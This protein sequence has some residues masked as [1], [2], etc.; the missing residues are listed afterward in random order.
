MALGPMS[1]LTLGAAAALAGAT[2]AWNVMWL[3]S[4][5]VFG[6][7]E[8]ALGFLVLFLPACAAIFLWNT[9]V[10]AAYRRPKRVAFIFGSLLAFAASAGPWGLFLGVPAVMLGCGLGASISRGPHA[11]GIF[12]PMGVAGLAFFFSY[13]VPE[14]AYDLITPSSRLITELLAE[15]LGLAV[16][17]LLFMLP[18]G[19]VV[20]LGSGPRTDSPVLARRIRS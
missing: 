8:W 10:G 4:V 1:V 6:L 12:G 20:L 15:F 5:E 11:L 14:W 16:L 3:Y 18:M 17:L 9:G 2:A 19:I 7:R 13:V